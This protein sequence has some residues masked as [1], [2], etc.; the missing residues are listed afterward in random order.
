MRELLP[1][2]QLCLL[3]RRFIPQS[4]VPNPTI[5]A[6]GGR[7]GSACNRVPQTEVEW[8]AC[9]NSWAKRAQHHRCPRA[10]ASR[11]GA[12]EG[13]GWPLVRDQGLFRS[14]ATAIT[15]LPP[16]SSLMRG[17]STEFAVHLARARLPCPVRARTHSP[18]RASSRLCARA[19]RRA[20]TRPFAF[21][22]AR[23]PLCAPFRARVRVLAKS[24]SSGSHF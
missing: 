14:R 17:F 8:V 2:S 5:S 11:C 21:V 7:G 3:L 22:P 23:A 18:F 1:T 13:M 6:A 24:L 20:L 19:A 15:V 10:K 9:V 16:A 12:P 4:T